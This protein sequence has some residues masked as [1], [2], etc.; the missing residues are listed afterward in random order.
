MAAGD[1]YFAI[2]ATFRFIHNRYGEE[3]LI[4]YWRTLGKNHY[5][6]LIDRFREDGLASVEAYWREFFSHEPGGRVEV[7]RTEGSVE[8]EV[9]ECPAIKWLNDHGREIMP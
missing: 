8:I 5:R 4:Q 1:F 2:N 7:T 6:S 9:A 3:G